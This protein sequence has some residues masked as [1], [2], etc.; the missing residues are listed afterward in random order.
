MRPTT[1]LRELAANAVMAVPPLRALRVRRGRTANMGSD[2][3]EARLIDAR[4]RFYLDNIGLD[5]FVGATVCEIGPG[6]AFPFAADAFRAGAARYIAVDRF[7]D[8]WQTPADSRIT[9]IADAVEAMTLDGT[10]DILVSFNV[11]EHVTDP[12]RAFR[13]MAQALTPTGV[14][15]HRVDYGPH[16]SWRGDDDP[17]AFLTVPDPL[18]RAMGSARGYPNRVRHTALRGAARQYGLTVRDRVTRRFPAVP[19][20]IADD[21]WDAE[22]I[23]G[24]RPVDFAGAPFTLR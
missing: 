8:G 9:L 6:D 14:M 19:Q 22:L 7:A 21:V 23:A 13:T 2:D 16:Q 1:I 11:L 18:W 5:R 12:A 15:L 20:G 17:A 4:R 3:A 24:H 10:V